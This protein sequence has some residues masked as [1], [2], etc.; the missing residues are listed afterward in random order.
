MT[1]V[2]YYFPPDKYRLLPPPQQTGYD[3]EVTALPDRVW[4]IES[5]D[6]GNNL[7][8]RL[9]ETSKHLKGFVRVQKVSTPR[10]AAILFERE[11]HY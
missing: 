8:S 9:A 5:G 11:P 2:H 1:P 10:F 6:P 3:T 4:V 7:E